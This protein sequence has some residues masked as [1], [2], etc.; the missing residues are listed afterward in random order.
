[1]DTLHFNMQVFGKTLLHKI[2]GVKFR[3]MAEFCSQR[4]NS[5]DA[6]FSLRETDFAFFLCPTNYI[7]YRFVKRKLY[8]FL[9]AKLNCF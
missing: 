2:A 3:R 6:C 9:K 4:K 1:M 7:I 5:G 8:F